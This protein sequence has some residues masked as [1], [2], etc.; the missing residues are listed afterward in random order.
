MLYPMRKSV[1]TGY[2][3]LNVSVSV[4]PKNKERVADLSLHILGKEN[5]VY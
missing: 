1:Q 3:Q 2:D 4:L 5:K